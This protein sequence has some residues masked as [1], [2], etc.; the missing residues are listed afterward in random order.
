MNFLLDIRR[1]CE[2]VFNLP[3]T[4]DY[5]IILK[6]FKNWKVLKMI[7]F[8]KL[9]KLS[10][11]M[12]ALINFTTFF[13]AVK[14]FSQIFCIYQSLSNIFE[15]KWSATFNF[16]MLFGKKLHK[17][18]GNFNFTNTTSVKIMPVVWDNLTEFS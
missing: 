4:F 18:L 11:Y 9:T 15:K 1:R 8:S 14:I 7:G 16:R 17:Y 13:Q 10:L 5:F 2:V 3:F 12:R 6:T